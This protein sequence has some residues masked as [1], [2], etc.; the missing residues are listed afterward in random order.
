MKFKGEVIEFIL[1][2]LESKPLLQAH[3]EKFSLECDSGNSWKPDIV[4][5]D[6]VTSD[7]KLMEEIKLENYEFGKPKKPRKHTHMEHMWRAG[8]RFC[9]V[10]NWCVPKYLLFPYLVERPRGFDA[11]AYFKN[12]DVILLDWSKTEHV[13]IL[14]KQIDR[15]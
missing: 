2:C 5:V 10:K 7:V 12:L 4:I 9:D 14:K 6:S 3:I 13:E 1:E 15:L 8:S 11:Y